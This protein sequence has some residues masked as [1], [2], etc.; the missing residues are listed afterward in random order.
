[1]EKSIVSVSFKRPTH[2]TVTY[3]TGFEYDYF[4]F[5]KI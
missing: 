1:M 3:A 2:E 4:N 5:Q